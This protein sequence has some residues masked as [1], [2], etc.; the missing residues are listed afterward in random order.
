MTACKP[1]GIVTFTTDFGLTDDYVGLL[2]GAVYIVDPSV[3]IVNLCHN[4]VPG[5]IH[6]AAFLLLHDH[7]QFPTGTVHVAVVDPGVGSHREILAARIGDHMFL[8]PNNGLL[9][10]LLERGPVHEVRKVTNEDLFRKP[11][12]NTFHGRDIFAPVAARLATGMPLSE[13]GPEMTE[14]H[15][16]TQVHPEM[17]ANGY[18]GRVML[19]DRF[20]NLITNLPPEALVDHTIQI[21]GTRPRVV[22]TFSQGNPGETICLVGS[23]QTVEVVINGGDAAKILGLGVGTAIRALSHA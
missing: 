5:E 13:V 9:H 6:A 2:H 11:I 19:V 21:A 3:H 1:S 10:P 23:K 4:L 18:I 15:K 8:A 12:S 14:W 7:N 16:I 22:D 17:E 20:G